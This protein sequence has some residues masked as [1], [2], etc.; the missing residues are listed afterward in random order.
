MHESIENYIM[1]E[2]LPEELE[3]SFKISGLSMQEFIEANRLV[4]SHR[5]MKIQ[6][7]K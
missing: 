4:I 3:R 7:N 5:I 1:R 6:Y 2:G